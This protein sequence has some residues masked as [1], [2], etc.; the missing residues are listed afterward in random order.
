MDVGEGETESEASTSGI[1]AAAK[2]W[3]Q[4]RAEGDEGETSEQFS[5]DLDRDD[6]SDDDSEDDEVNNYL[7]MLEQKSN[8]YTE[9]K[10]LAVLVGVMSWC[11]F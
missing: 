11:L 9:M 7:S 3:Q 4:S 2:A 6:E 5:A 1:L 10:G 8:Y